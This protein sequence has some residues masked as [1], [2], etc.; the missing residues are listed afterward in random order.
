MISFGGGYR[1]QPL[2]DLATDGIGDDV[3]TV[4]ASAIPVPSVS[5]L[6]PSG[7]PLIKAWKMRCIVLPNSAAA[8]FS[9]Q[10][11]SRRTAVLM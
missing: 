8:E 9:H 2:D 1:S 3:G 7:K 6:V 4:V 11:S 5:T 10:I